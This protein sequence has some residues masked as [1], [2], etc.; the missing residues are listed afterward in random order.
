MNLQPVLLLSRGYPFM[1]AF[2]AA[3][4]YYFP[5]FGHTAAYGPYAIFHARSAVGINFRFIV[6][7]LLENHQNRIIFAIP[8][9]DILIF[10]DRSSYPHRSYRQQC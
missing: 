4:F 1:L 10:P 9:R 7:Q 2:I 5:E 6:S 8:G 3:V